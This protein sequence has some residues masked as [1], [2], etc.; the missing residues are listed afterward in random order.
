MNV[1][2]P[3]EDDPRRIEVRAWFE[4]HPNPTYRDLAEVGYTAPHWPKPWGLGADPEL[5][6]IIDEE[7]ERAGLI[8]PHNV[9]TVALVTC[10]PALLTFGTEWQRQHYLPRAL[11]CQDLWVQLFSEPFCGSDL[12]ALR[13]TARREGDHYI[14]NGQKIWT[15]GAHAAQVGVLLAR[16]DPSV[17]KHRGISEFLLDFDLPGVSVRPVI[18]IAGPPGH[19]N[20]VFFDNVRVPANRLVGEEGQGWQ[21]MHSQMQ[22]ERA[23]LGR[24]GIVFGMGPTAREMVRGLDEIG[25]L[26][27]ESVR[28]RAADLFVEGEVLRILAMRTLSDQINGRPPGPGAALHKMLASVHA[29]RFAQLAKT[30]QGLDGLIEHVQPF[31]SQSNRKANAEIWTVDYQDWDHGFWFSPG[32][33][34]GAG[35]QEILKNVVAERVLDLPREV[36][37]TAKQPWSEMAKAAQR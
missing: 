8:L 23:A 37:V 26:D 33:T 30:A 15:G 28:D 6:I 1:D 25:A 31:P 18:D 9:N 17:P 24:P 10:G 2:L 19:F 32:N 14:I 27:D 20:Q 11:A 16:T 13:T 7:I 3:G 29:Q 34:L 22:S 4:A 35:A 5:Q 21:I 12:A 36:D